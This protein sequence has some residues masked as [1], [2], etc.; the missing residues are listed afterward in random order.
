MVNVD[1]NPL[2]AG[3]AVDACVEPNP[4]KPV[5]VCGAPKAAV[6]PNVDVPPPNKLGVVVVD[7][8]VAPNA[9]VPPNKLGFDVTAAVWVPKVPN[10]PPPNVGAVEAGA[11]PKAGAAPNAGVD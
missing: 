7:A 9:P 3:A 1:P 4:P 5:L 10:P 6:F 8:G 2:N 11:D